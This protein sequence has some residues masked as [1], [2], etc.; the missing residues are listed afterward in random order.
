[1]VCTMDSEILLNAG[2]TILGGG[3]AAIFGFVSQW[4]YAR[5]QRKDGIKKIQ[6]LL[7]P[8]F[9]ALYNALMWERNVIKE[10]K[11]ISKPNFNSICDY[12]DAVLTYLN[13]KGRLH[14][15]SRMWDVILSSGNLINMNRI[16]IETIQSILQ[17]VRMYNKTMSQ[18][19]SK[20]HQDIKMKINGMIDINVDVLDRYFVHWEQTIN[21]AIRW[22]N[23]LDRLSWINY[24]QI[25]ATAPIQ[26]AT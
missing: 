2:Y 14:V 24:D 18:S 19:T 6:D 3:L 10:A 17:C 1:M 9:K 21:E 12:E 23:M 11:S 5:K 25:K 4:A 22:F 8:E 7:K 26:T 16:E 13:D 15:E 20:M